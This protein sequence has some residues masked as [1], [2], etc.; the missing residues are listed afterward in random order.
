M[1]KFLIGVALALTLTAGTAA[2]QSVGRDAR[3]NLRVEGRALS[4]IVQY[5]REQSGANIVVLEGADENI[6]LEL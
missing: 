2:A 5:L 1:A 6:S 3:V 4:D